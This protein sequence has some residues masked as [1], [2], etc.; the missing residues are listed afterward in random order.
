MLN[1]V[2]F[3]DKQPKPKVSNQKAQAVKNNKK[4]MIV[5]FYLQGYN[6][7]EIK[8]IIENA[9]NQEVSNEYIYKVISIYNKTSKAKQLSKGDKTREMVFTYLDMGVTQSKIAETLGV[10]KSYV[11]K[12][13]KDYIILGYIKR[14]VNELRIISLL[15]ITEREIQELKEKYSRY[16]ETS[17]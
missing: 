12:L 4:S 15:G 8:K 7:N 9:F 16:L 11:S 14:G 2:Q 6:A 5:E 17:R 10:S 3:K 1:P 13:N